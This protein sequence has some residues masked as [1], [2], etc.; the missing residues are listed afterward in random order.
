MNLKKNKVTAT[1]LA[2]AA[3]VSLLAAGDLPKELENTPKEEIKD[4]S[5]YIYGTKAEDPVA[6]ANGKTVVLKPAPDAEKYNGVLMGVYDKT[7][8]KATRSSR[9]PATKY[10]MKSITGIRF[11]GPAKMRR[12]RVKTG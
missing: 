6:P 11:G 3:S 10:R 4:V 5:R 7:Y 9:F 2:A 12:F 8:H 1:V